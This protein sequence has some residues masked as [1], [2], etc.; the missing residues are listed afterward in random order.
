MIMSP[1][2]NITRIHLIGRKGVE[3]IVRQVGFMLSISLPMVCVVFPSI[4]V[5]CWR[6]FYGLR[7][8]IL[9]AFRLT[10]WLNCKLHVHKNESCTF[11]LTT[12]LYIFHRCLPMSY[13]TKTAGLPFIRPNKNK[14][15][16][17]LLHAQKI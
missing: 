8:S 1:M 11:R 2:N 13:I 17:F 7:I 5:V 12:L 9:Y 15:L 4:H 3:Q 14:I 16:S 6:F 10:C